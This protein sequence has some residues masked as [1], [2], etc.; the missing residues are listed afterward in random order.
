M[1]LDVAFNNS[2]SSVTLEFLIEI[3][4]MPCFSFH[5][6]SA[7]HVIYN[8]DVREVI[9]PSIKGQMTILADHMPIVATLTQG[10]V[11]IRLSD[12]N[13]S[14]DFE[15]LGGFLDMNQNKC[16]VFATID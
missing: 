8:A 15:I 5:I 9:A 7:H 1:T 14:K 10:T 16:T 2:D 6:L 11:S 4:I 13:I 3:N 12:E